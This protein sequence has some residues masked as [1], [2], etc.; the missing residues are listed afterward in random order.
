MARGD[1]ASAKRLGYGALAFNIAGVI[2]A[3]VFSYCVF[4]SIHQS[5][6]LEKS[7]RLLWLLL[8]R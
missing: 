6:S 2:G 1:Y 8:Q 7:L 5:L 3:V 4:L